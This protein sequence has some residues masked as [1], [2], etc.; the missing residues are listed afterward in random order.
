MNVEDSVSRVGL[1]DVVA[2]N[3][4]RP[5]TFSVPPFEDRVSLEPGDLAQLVSGGVERLWVKVTRA[6]HLPEGTYYSGSVVSEP[7]VVPVEA[8]DR[9][10]FRPR[11]VV[12]LDRKSVVRPTSRRP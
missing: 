4:E 11:H 12:D 5:G 2:W 8:G 9:V 6:S 10:D 1:T 3:R 7:S